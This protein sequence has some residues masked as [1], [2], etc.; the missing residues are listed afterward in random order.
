MHT[1]PKIICSL[2][3]SL[4]LPLTSYAND[5]GIRVSGTSQLTTAPDIAHFTL[6]ITAQGKDLPRI[7]NEIDLKTSK[8]VAL[9]KELGI[10]AEKIST[11]EVSINP[12][13]NYQTRDFLGYEV[14]RSVKLTLNELDK[15]SRLVDGV[16]ES[17]VTTIRHISLDTS[18]RKQLE[19]AALE[20]ATADAEKKALALA[21]ST[22]V[23]LGKVTSIEES[24]LPSA[25]P[26]LF[27]E[28]RAV[29]SQASGAFEPGEIT[30]GATVIVRYSIR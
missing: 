2:L 19:I 7:K 13:Y 28:N 17:G 3:L 27:R 16:I 6:A 20:S 11:S 10:A 22:G 4:L 15:Y 9:A 24:G 21:R 26:V 30:V 25:S 8:S 5:Y 1:T 29:S 14:S 23:R 18:K 12:Q